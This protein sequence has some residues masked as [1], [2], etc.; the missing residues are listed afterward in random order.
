MEME[1]FPLSPKVCR[2]CPSE[3]F[4]SDLYLPK[5]SGVREVINLFIEIEVLFF[6]N[7]HPE[8]IFNYLLVIG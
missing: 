1:S 6:Y 2:L 5:N 4:L 3:E 8:H 7:F